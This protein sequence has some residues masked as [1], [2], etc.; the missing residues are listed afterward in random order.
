MNKGELQ[1]Q[2]E[3][4]VLNDNK[5]IPINRYFKC[6]WIKCSDQRHRMADWIKKQ[7]PLICCLQE[8]P[9]RKIHTD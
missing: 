5:Y 2:L 4:K 3:N 8:T 1:K 7:E 9:R 6:Q